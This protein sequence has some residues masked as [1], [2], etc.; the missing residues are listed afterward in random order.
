MTIEPINNFMVSAT[1]KLPG[2]I[3]S[4]LE[5]RTKREIY[6]DYALLVFELPQPLTMEDFREEI[7]NSYGTTLLYQHARSI[8][9]DF[10]HSICAFQEPGTGEMFQINGSTDSRGLISS[11][12]VKIYCSMEYMM[13]ELH[14][15]LLRIAKIPG[16]IS[17]ILGEDELLSYFL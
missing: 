15:E 17:Y 16:E 10:G 14:R 9:T 8:Q 12:D 6:S 7:D 1:L 13:A 5:D 2:I 3:A 4:R 11:V